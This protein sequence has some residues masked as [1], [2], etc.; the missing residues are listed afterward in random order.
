MGGLRSDFCR[1]LPGVIVWGC[2]GTGGDRSISRSDR[3]RRRT[4]NAQAGVC[5][6]S[7]GKLS[8]AAQRRRLLLGTALATSLVVL[9]MLSQGPA[10]AQTL[11]P[12]GNGPDPINIVNQGMAIVCDNDVTRMNLAGAAINLRTNMANQF[13]TVDNTGAW[14]PPTRG[15]SPPPTGFT[16][17]QQ[18]PAPTS[19]STMTPSS[20][21]MDRFDRM[22]SEPTA[23]GG[24]LTSR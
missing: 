17:E 9:P 4:A 19:S 14:T 18:A 5:P 3:V 22:A 23:A 7:Q 10:A 2:M 16:S 13:I 8:P 24:P 6:L 12:Q 21:P 11:C 1:R 15:I 20:M